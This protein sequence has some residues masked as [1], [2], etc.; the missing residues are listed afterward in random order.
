LSE[1]L[2]TFVALGTIHRLDLLDCH[3]FK[4]FLSSYGEWPDDCIPPL[5]HL[6]IQ[7]CYDQETGD[8]A[9]MQRG[10]Q[11]MMGCENLE[12][13]YLNWDNEESELTKSIALRV[14]SAKKLVYLRLQQDF[15]ARANELDAALE[16]ADWLRIAK[17]LPKLRALG[18]QIDEHHLAPG[19][20]HMS[21]RR[22][23]WVS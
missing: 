12:S 13:L 16:P 2:P 20:W 7:G 21:I 23:F 9:K 18:Y 14:D 17:S 4:S 6:F 10:I 8:D 3:G 22:T 19:L 15:E 5:R 1:S 11:R